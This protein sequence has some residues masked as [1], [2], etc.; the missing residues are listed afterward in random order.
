MCEVGP[1]VTSYAY[2]GQFS[3]VIPNDVT[4]SQQGHMCTFDFALIL[5]SVHKTKFADVDSRQ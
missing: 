2:R 5:C 4:M 1:R 3:F